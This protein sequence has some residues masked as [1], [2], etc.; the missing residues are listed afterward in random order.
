MEAK[1]SQVVNYCDHEGNHATWLGGQG[2]EPPANIRELIPT[3]YS[4]SKASKPGNPYSTS[5][6]TLE[7]VPAMMRQR[8]GLR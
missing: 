1:A 4:P 5:G 6:C 2:E 3:S 8:L 7:Q